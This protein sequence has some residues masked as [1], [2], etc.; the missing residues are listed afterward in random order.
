MN[1][2]ALNDVLQ[3]IHDHRS[4]VIFIHEKPD[5]DA[6]GSSTA[7]ALF[8]RSLDRKAVIASPTPI[9]RRLSFAAAADVP[10]ICNKEALAKVDADAA[11][12]VDVASDAM[13]GDLASAL[14]FPIG[15][16]LDHHKVHTVT[17]EAKYV[18]AAAS[19]CGEIIFSLISL[20]AMITGAECFTQRIAAALYTA[21]ASDTGCFRYGN[22]TA[23]TH[24]M[25]QKLFTLGIDAEG[26]N[27]A[28]F[29]VKPLSQIRTERMGYEKLRLFYHDRLAVV[30]FT[31][32]DL[33][34]IGA[35]DDDT[36]TV[37]Q[38]VRMI[39]GVEIGVLMREKLLPDGKKVYKFSVRGN[40]SADM[41]AL[42]ACFG[43]GG[44][45]KAA[46]CTIDADYETAMAK[47][48]EAA[49]DYVTEG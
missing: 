40:T 35:T 12:T 15:Y 19:A 29:E 27:R 47:F 33:E 6:V 48:V 10:Y 17:A 7:L 43:G 13:L 38:M 42:C 36:D 21:I 30:G 34:K 25:A 11:L 26:I 23:D 8:L 5:G 46:G 18:D 49:A 3:F 2:S 1:Y 32:A 41:A 22:T 39:E 4:F 37:A 9:S 44:H 14:P 28:L 20:Y 45:K 16:A 24:D 31:R